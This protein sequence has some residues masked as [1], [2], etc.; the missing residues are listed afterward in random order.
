M[1]DDKMNRFIDNEDGTITDTETGLMWSKD[2]NLSRTYK[3]WEQ[4]L[5]YVNNLT[6]CSYSDWRLPTI[7]ELMSLLDYG[8]YGPALPAGHPFINVQS[9]NYWSS[10]AVASYQ[11]YAWIVYMWDGIVSYD[12]KSFTRN[13][14][15]P[16]RS[17]VTGNKL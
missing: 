12:G 14:V 16:V 6:I 4:T 7:K 5:D 1:M 9:S 3:T 8:Q 13:Y 15:C 10:T 2:A 11:S 17:H